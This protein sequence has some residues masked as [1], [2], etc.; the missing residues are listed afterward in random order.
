ME[1]F[2]IN[3]FNVFIEF[4]LDREK[5][6]CMGIRFL[7]SNRRGWEAVST[8]SL[9]YANSTKDV[10]C[11]ERVVHPAAVQLFNNAFRILQVLY[12]Q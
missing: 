5:V 3:Q 2:L 8:N 12:T 6:C 1:I 11:N 10:L 4:C 9:R 7:L